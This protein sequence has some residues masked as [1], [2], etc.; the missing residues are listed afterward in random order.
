MK[1]QTIFPAYFMKPSNVDFKNGWVYCYEPLVE[2][3][4]KRT[5]KTYREA[6]ELFLSIR[7]QR[8]IERFVKK[9]GLPVQQDT[10][11]YNEQEQ[12]FYNMAF[13]LSWVKVL[14]DCLVCMQENKHFQSSDVTKEE[15]DL[16][17]RERY[18]LWLE[19][20]GGI[21]ELEALLPKFKGN[22][23]GLKSLG[24]YL[25][26]GQEVTNLIRSKIPAA[27]AII[28][29]PSPAFMNGFPQGVQLVPAD[30]GKR[31]W[32]AFAVPE[33]TPLKRHLRFYIEET[34]RSYFS[35]SEGLTLLPINSKVVFSLK[36]GSRPE[37][38]LSMSTVLD[39]MIHSLLSHWQETKFK[40]CL[41]CNRMFDFIRA[42][43]VFCH[44]NCRKAHARKSH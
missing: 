17:Y 31:D 38:Q 42:S 16:P 28:L 43:K 10:G 19:R 26:S 33:L 25:D 11:Q 22:L 41:H 1:S 14:I 13:T 2:S 7:N 5:D 20:P 35:N 36:S 9:Y 40:S 27:R 18:L 23:T 6:L 44:D 32:E 39:G 24:D 4:K 29:K 21:A 3:R 12:F 15:I 37:L 34:L 30:E 8:G